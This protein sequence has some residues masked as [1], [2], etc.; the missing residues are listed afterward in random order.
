MQ[1]LNYH[2]LRYFFE[3]ARRGSMS[4]AARA[5]RVTQPTVSA[6]IRELED[7][8]G[9]RLLQREGSRWTLTPLGQHVHTYAA[10]IFSLGEELSATLQ[11]PV[12]APP[13]RIGVVDAL[14]KLVIHALIEP[15]MAAAP[16]GI[17]LRQGELG[18]LVEKLRLHQLDLVLS[19]YPLAPQHAAVHNHPL[20][21]SPVGVFGTPE[22]CRTRAPMPESL[23]GAPF[24]LL[25]RTAS[26]RRTLDHYLHRHKV[27]VQVVGEF[28][29]S[30]LLKVFAS[31]GHG[32]IVAPLVIEEHLREAFGLQLAWAVP[33][34]AE[35]LFL[36]SVER[37]VEH[38]AA[39]H[40]IRS[41][42]A[43]LEAIA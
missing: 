9:G 8:C 14:P 22:L 40:I 24:L 38:P 33:E 4:A 23:D 21:R 6:Q 11:G 20:G 1:H 39:A 27:E 19:D 41:A 12:V 16:G 10:D 26:L 7:Q 30:A 37:Q 43:S 36:L 32:F 15:A 42:R 29:D 25:P 5:L 31:K 28:Q 17:H 34:G 35:D 13:L 3:T 18:M 2:H